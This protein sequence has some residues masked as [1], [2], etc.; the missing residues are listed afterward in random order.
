MT[1]VAADKGRT[2]VR[3]P[4]ITVIKKAIMPTNILSQKNSCSLGNFY[5]DD[6][7]FEG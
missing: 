6:C 4:I 2:F 7:E 3:S 5:V 1:K